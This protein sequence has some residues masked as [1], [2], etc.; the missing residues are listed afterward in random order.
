MT[1]REHLHEVGSGLT[2]ERDAVEIYRR[3]GITMRAS[4]T[5]TCRATSG[6]C[7]S[8][9]NRPA[10]SAAHGSIVP[11]S[12]PSG[13]GDV[14]EE[15]EF[16]GALAR[17]VRNCL[18]YL[19]GRSPVHLRKEPDRI[20]ARRWR[21]YPEVALRETLVNALYHRSY[22]PDV[23]GA[24]QGVL[25]PGSLG[26]HQLSGPGGRG[27]NREHFALRS[28]RTPPSRRY[29]PA[30]AASASFFKE[31]G[32]AEARL[33]GLRKVAS[34]MAANGSPAPRYDFDKG[35]TY[36]RVTL[37]AHPEYAALVRGPRGRRV[38]RPGGGRTR[39]TI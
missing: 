36:F 2:E 6:C 8:R 20:E 22:E 38:A 32:L 33:T 12:Q 4:T 1:V 27:S 23:T 17:Q 34:A 10:G 24:D 15:Q 37:P 30:T 39:R 3:M 18:R 16:R 31:I 7:S 26:D 9:P 19:Y 14:Q 29:P 21:A 11:C 13:T 5:T 35:R 25:V 28:L